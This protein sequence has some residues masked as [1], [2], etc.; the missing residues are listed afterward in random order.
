MKKN[1][2]QRELASWIIIIFF[3]F[4]LRNKEECV[5]RCVALRGLQDSQDWQS[6]S[7]W[8]ISSYCC[9]LRKPNHVHMFFSDRYHDKKKK[10]NRTKKKIENVHNSLNPLH[11]NFKGCICLSVFIIFKLH[12][13]LSNN[14]LKKKKKRG[15]NCQNKRFLIS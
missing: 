2:S 4:F 6:Y 9:R 7:Y 8:L 15:Y 10:K 5:L 1:V 13:F 14:N 3:F 12:N 11:K